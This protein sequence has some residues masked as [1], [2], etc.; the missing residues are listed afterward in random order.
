MLPWRACQFLKGLV[1]SYLLPIIIKLE[2]ELGM[3]KA[4]ISK[5]I[6]VRLFFIGEYF[7]INVVSVISNTPSNQ[8]F[9]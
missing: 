7:R 5:T 9:A 2:R 1:L 4:G 6:C 3:S 8:A